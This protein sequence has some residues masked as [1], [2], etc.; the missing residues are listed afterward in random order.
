MKK[1]VISAAVATVFAVVTT[2][3]YADDTTPPV[4]SEITVKGGTIN[5]EGSVVNAACGVDAGSS[6]LTVRLG[7]FRMADFEKQ[8][9]ETGRIPFSIK[10]HSCDPSVASM[11]AITFNGT[12]SDADNTAF[13]LQGAGAAKNVAL[14]ITDASSKAVT[15]GQ[16]SSAM[17][18]IEGENELNY[19]ASL[20]ATGDE[21][22]AGSA[23]VTTNFMVTYS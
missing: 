8:G 21:V 16:K 6:N 9:D 14:K 1:H 2:A 15:P 10:L 7:Q 23:N 22:S 3:A 19:N 11:A 20:I 12:A 13:A 4:K 17:P 18:L 5:F